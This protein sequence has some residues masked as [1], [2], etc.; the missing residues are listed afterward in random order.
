MVHEICSRTTPV[1]D[2]HRGGM[3]TPLSLELEV[4]QIRSEA[5]PWGSD[6]VEIHASFSLG[7]Y[8]GV[9]AYRP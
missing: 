5:F 1:N 7:S 9:V 8:R 2:L 4:P 3:P 6:N